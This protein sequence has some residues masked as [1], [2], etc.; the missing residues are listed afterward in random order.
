MLGSLW[1][2]VAYRCTRSCWHCAGVS[3]R[4]GG[5]PLY[6]VLLTLC[7]GLF[8]V[9][10]PTLYQV[11]L[12]LCW[13]LFEVWWPTTVP[14]LVDTVLG[15]TL[16]LWG[17]VAYPV[18]GLVDTVLGSLWGLVAY[19]VPGLVDTVLGSLWGLVA[20]P[21]PGL[22]DTVLGS[23]W[24]L[25]AYP[26]P[27]LVDTVLGSLWGLVAYP[28]PGLVDTVLGSLWGL[29]AYHCTRS[30]WHCAG[31]SLRSGGLPLYQVLLTLCWGLFEVWCLP[32]T[33]S[34][35]W[36]LSVVWWPTA[37]PGLRWHC[38]GVSLRL[39]AYRC[40]RSCWHCAG[41]SLRSGGLPLYQVLLTLC[42]GLFEVWWPTAVPGLVDT[43]LGSL[44]GLVAYRCTRSC[45]HCAGV[46]LRSGGLPGLSGAVSSLDGDTCIENRS[47]FPH[48]S[49]ENC[50][51][52][53]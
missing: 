30:C 35:Y 53:H 26:V 39:V 51:S 9:W 8:E 21:V 1:G 5:L 31:V 42:W 44:W 11:L 32:C 29:V 34:C 40:T 36:G 49:L 33:R 45:W 27:G 10:W 24:G 17:L 25:V 23:L 28:V 3:L 38:A 12:T 16:S 47:P 2:L 20:Y 18:P 50:L 7:W 15:P 14:G 22:V 37:V 4:S 46:S 19:P 48:C 6:Q 13:G 52:I 43:V 41:V